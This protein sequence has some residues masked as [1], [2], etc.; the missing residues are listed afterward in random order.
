MR[1]RVLNVLVAVNEEILAYAGQDMIGVGIIDSFQVVD[2]VEALEGEFQIELDAEC[3]TAE[4]FAN[5]D[6]ILSLMERFIG[7]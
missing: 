4:N 2:I 7:K 3:I 1:E 6:S 5:K